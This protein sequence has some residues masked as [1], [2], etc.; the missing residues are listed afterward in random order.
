MGSACVLS[1]DRPQQCMPPCRGY[2]ETCLVPVGRENSVPVWLAEWA[3]GRPF[4]MKHNCHLTRTWIQ[5][6]A[7]HRPQAAAPD[8]CSGHPVEFVSVIK[9]AVCGNGLCK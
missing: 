9:V 3:D 4:L 2:L 8:D 5:G 1:P 7:L 6:S